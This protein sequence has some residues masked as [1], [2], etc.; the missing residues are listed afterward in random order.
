MSCRIGVSLT[1]I[2]SVT[3][4]AGVANGNSSWSARMSPTSTDP[5]T[6]TGAQ[7]RE[8]TPMTRAHR[9][10]ARD[11]GQDRARGFGGR[12]QRTDRTVAE[13]RRGHRAQ[14]AS[15]L[16]RGTGCGVADRCQAI[17]S[18]TEVHR[19]PSRPGQGDGL[20]TTRDNGL[21]LSRWWCPDLVEQA[22]TDGICA[23]IS[24]VTIRGWLSQDALKPCQHRSWIFITDPDFAVKAQRVLDL[25]DRT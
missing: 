23:S 21:P 7:R 9:A 10:T 1:N 20:H 11:T 6:L 5:I 4:E 17:G 18:P 16:V 25:Y 12:A 19:C 2:Q 3:D 14:V 13:E 22:I 24:P 15:P 8:L